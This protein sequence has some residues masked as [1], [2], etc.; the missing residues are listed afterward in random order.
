MHHEPDAWQIMPLTKMFFNIIFIIINFLLTDD[1]SA[2]M[3]TSLA[4]DLSQVQECEWKIV[5]H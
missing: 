5:F 1:C 3:K 4:R 2:E